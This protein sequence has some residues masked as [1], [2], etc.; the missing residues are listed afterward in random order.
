MVAIPIP[1]SEESTEFREKSSK[2]AHVHPKTALLR[3]RKPIEI[4]KMSHVDSLKRRPQVHERTEFILAKCSPRRWKSDSRNQLTTY[5]CFHTPKSFR[6]T[7]QTRLLTRHGDIES[8]L[9][10]NYKKLLARDANAD[11]THGRDAERVWAAAGGELRTVRTDQAERGVAGEKHTVS[12]LIGAWWMSA[13]TGE[14]MFSWRRTVG[15]ITNRPD[16]EFCTFWFR[17]LRWVSALKPLI[18]T[19]F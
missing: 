15:R 5:D 8:E 11:F 10:R 7:Q 2:I 16:M 14:T 13:P 18:P 19:H 4:S 3:R 6:E 12:T 9:T 1:R 17:H